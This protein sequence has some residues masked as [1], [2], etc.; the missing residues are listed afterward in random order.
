MTNKKFMSPRWHYSFY[1][2]ASML[3]SFFAGISMSDD[4]LRHIS[5]AKYFDSMKNWGEVFPYSLFSQYDP[6]FG[7]HEFLKIIL[8]VV[9][10][11][12]VHLIINTCAFFI[13]M[14]LMDK[15]IRT[16]IKYKLDSFVYILT[17]LIII[18]TSYRYT[19]IRPDMLSGFYI[20]I[21]IL[22]KDRFF[23]TLLLTVFY[24]PF[25]YLFFL[26]TGSMGLVYITQRKWKSFWGVFL[27]SVV[28]LGFY[29]WHDASNY[30]ETVYH[31][32]IDQKLRM[33][34]SVREGEPVFSMLSGVSYMI[35]LPLFLGVSL[36]MI[37]KNYAYFKQNTLAT[38]LLITSILWVNQYRYFHLFMPMIFV[39]G[40][41]YALNMNKKIFFHNLRKYQV[42]GKRFFSYSK[43][44]KLF[45]LIALPYSMLMLAYIYSFQSVEMQ[46]IK[47]KEFNKEIY[48]EKTILSN[49]LNTE[50]YSALYYNPSIKMIPSC[51][52]GWFEHENKD[53]KDIY[54]RMINKEGISERELNHLIRNV[55][56][57]FYMHYQKKS[58]RTLNLKTL[59]D[60]GIIPITIYEN[61]ILFKVEQ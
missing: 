21:L 37:V 31:I 30:I 16:Y 42:L 13:L 12:S 4:G 43:N 2:I 60:F 19:M 28:T 25:Y 20:M 17:L 50:M 7:W 38:F 22:V 51:S 49:T 57:D 46:V 44:K 52:I 5:F 18:L 29:I 11:E 41:S 14:I 32:L 33:G 61:K 35:L 15:F 45:Y 27:G 1:A 39:L 36:Y 53:L 40:L 55:K 48:N 59:K 54:I 34:V 3:F 56:A 26:Y 47:G 10:Y 58:K 23:L 24:G 6:W 9:P 8:K